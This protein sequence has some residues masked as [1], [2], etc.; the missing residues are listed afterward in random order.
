MKMVPPSFLYLLY[1][2]FENLKLKTL[3]SKLYLPYAY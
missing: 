2:N 1:T 3:P